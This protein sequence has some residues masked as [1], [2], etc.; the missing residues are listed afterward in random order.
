MAAVGLSSPGTPVILPLSADAM[1]VVLIFLCS[2]LAPRLVLASAAEQEKEKDPFHYDY[3]TLRIGGLV[4][5]V[6]L[7]S[8]GILLILSR[9]C[10][11][12]FAQKPRAP[13]D[14]EAQVENLITANAT[15]P[16]KAE[17]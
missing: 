5:A 11:C 16:Q 4:F 17:N 12:S 14:E 10:K 3:Q 13:G 1:E 6:V 9:R 15:E 8:V 2:L 7:F